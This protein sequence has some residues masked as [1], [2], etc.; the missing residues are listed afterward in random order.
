MGTLARFVAYRHASAGY[1]S[2][3]YSFTPLIVVGL[4][5]L[6]L[7]ESISITQALGGML[8]VGGGVAAARIH[9]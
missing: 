5:Y 2:M 4:S 7:S 9:A 3:I 6:I 1:I 8:V